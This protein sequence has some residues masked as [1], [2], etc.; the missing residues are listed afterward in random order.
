MSSQKRISFSEAHATH[1][2]EW[3]VMYWAPEAIDD[4]F[5][6]CP[7]CQDIG[8]RLETFIGKKTAAKVRRIIRKSRER[9]EASNSLVV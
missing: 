4:P 8:K 1:I 3:L 5:G 9:E 2:Y 7:F 6:G